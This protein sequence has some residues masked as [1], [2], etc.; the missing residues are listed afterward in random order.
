MYLEKGEWIL[1]REIIFF[2]KFKMLE[3]SGQ[4]NDIPENVL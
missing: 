4:K 1:G 3:I 2:K